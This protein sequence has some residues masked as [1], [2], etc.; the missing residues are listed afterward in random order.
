MSVYEVFVDG[1][2]RGQGAGPLVGHGAAAVVIYENKKLIGQYARALGRRTNNEAEYE[3][4]IAGL[5]MCWAAKLN[6][7][8]IYSDSKLVVNQVTGIWKCKNIKL[9]P[10]LLSVKEIQDEFRFRIVHVPRK[11]VTEADSL[12]SAILDR[13]LVDETVMG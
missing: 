1:A 4:V 9:K 10:L 8:I 6:D 11:Y 5:L 2:S 13:L 7:P 12:A 3:A